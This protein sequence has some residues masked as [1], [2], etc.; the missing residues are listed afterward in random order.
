M[1]AP[2]CVQNKDVCQQKAQVQR[3]QTDTK[4]SQ[5]RDRAQD[6]MS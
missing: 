4:E 2:V 5:E 1:S 3:G 6:N